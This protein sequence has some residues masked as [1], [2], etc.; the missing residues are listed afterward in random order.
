MARLNKFRIRVKVECAAEV[1]QCAAIRSTSDAVIDNSVRTACAEIPSAIAVGAWWGD[2]RALD[3][4][5]MEPGGNVDLA[6]IIRDNPDID[7]AGDARERLEIARVRAGWPA[8]NH[9]IVPG[10]TLVAAT[11]VVSTAVSFTKG[12]YPGQELVERMDSRGS[13]APRTLRRIPRASVP[14]SDPHSVA[15]GDALSV[16]G[17]DVGIVTSVAGD[18]VLA[19]VSRNADVGEPV[20]PAD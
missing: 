15:V 14:G 17:T 4:L 3:V 1:R 2:G 13:T 6:W 9:E 5:P 12:C 19:Y 18:W 7:I 10:E 11:G 20:T 16:D 8:M